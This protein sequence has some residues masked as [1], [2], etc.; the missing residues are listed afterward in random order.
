MLEFLDGQFVLLRRERTRL[1][2]A[3]RASIAQGK[4]GAVELDAARLTAALEVLRPDG[5]GW[6]DGQ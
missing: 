1:I 6:R 3:H 4:D 2:D 5:K